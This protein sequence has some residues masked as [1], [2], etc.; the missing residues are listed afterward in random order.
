MVYSLDWL[1][2][3]F[4]LERPFED[5]RGFNFPRDHTIVEL[6]GTNQFSKRAYVLDPNG[7]KMLTLLW[8]PH[9]KIIDERLCLVEVANPLLYNDYWYHYVVELFAGRNKCSFNNITRLDLCADWQMTPERFK[10]LRMLTDNDAYVVKKRKTCLFA[11][12]RANDEK[13]ERDLIQMS[14]GAKESDVKFKIYNKSRELMENSKERDSFSKPYIV[15]KWKTD[16]MD[17]Y[18]VWRWEVSLTSVSTKQFFGSSITLD[19]LSI[20]DYWNDLLRYLYHNSFKIRKNQ[21][22]I[23]KSYDENVDFLPI[24]LPTEIRQGIFRK[25]PVKGERSAYNF[26][27]M[28]NSLMKQFAT[29]ECACSPIRYDLAHTIRHLVVSANLQDYLLNRWGADYYNLLQW[30]ETQ[31]AEQKVKIYRSI[32][33]L[34]QLKIF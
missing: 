18:N 16:G 15:G 23:N 24:P 29:V 21:G 30:Q 12:I 25:R 34:S 1:S 3:S 32:E 4:I 7:A 9:S 17:I 28:L 5:A 31:M 33:D 13:V 6:S 22:H 20:E 2:A 19:N 26:I 11:D 14:W 27:T 10:V 8:Y